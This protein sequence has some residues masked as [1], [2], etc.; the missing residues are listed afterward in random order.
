MTGPINIDL[1]VDGADNIPMS[2]DD[3]DAI[4]LQVDEGGGGGGGGTDTSD[5]TL[6]SGAEMLDGV[7][8]YARGSKYTG[9]IPERSGSDLTAAGDTVTVPAGHYASPASKAVSAGSAGTPATTIT[10]N[11]TIVVSPL[12][13][14]TAT[15]S[16]TQNVTPTVTPGYVD[17][18]NAG[19]IT[20]EGSATEQLPVWSGGSY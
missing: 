18:G 17:E 13:L 20:V 11:P 6:S 16:K 19:T 8:A 4:M 2:I 7:T 10:A 14:I 3:G 9:T 15:V 12:G 5:A 1:A